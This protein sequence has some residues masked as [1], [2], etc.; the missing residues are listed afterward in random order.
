MF[1]AANFCRA[2]KYTKASFE[3]LE[4]LFDDEKQLVAA[5]HSAISQR[6]DKGTQET[7]ETIQDVFP[8]IKVGEDRELRGRI[9]A[10]ISTMDFSGLQDDIFRRRQ[11]GTGLWFLNASKFQNWVHTARQTLFCPGMKGAGKTII[12]AT[13]IDYL[14]KIRTDDVG[15]AYVL[16]QYKSPKERIDQGAC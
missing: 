6:S 14:S 15:L 10:W 2:D 1:V 7:E 8:N 16:Y 4:E 5:I 11:D 13:V 3:K 12:A 9:C